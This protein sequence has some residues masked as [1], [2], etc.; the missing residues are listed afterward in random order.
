MA[1][2]AGNYPLLTGTAVV[3]ES[4]GSAFRKRLVYVGKNYPGHYSL[5]GEL[6]YADKKYHFFN[7]PI[8]F[9]VPIKFRGKKDCVLVL[10]H[11][12]FDIVPAEKWGYKFMVADESRIQV[13]ED[14]PV[15]RI[16]PYLEKLRMPIMPESPLTENARYLYRTPGAFVGLVACHYGDWLEDGRRDV[17]LG[18]APSDAFG[19]AVIRL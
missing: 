8:L 2:A 6:M 12:D 15:E 19:V 14:A 5:F 9:E 10:E 16:Y 11:P 4:P 17:V 1:A 7:P 13:L 3:Y 18:I